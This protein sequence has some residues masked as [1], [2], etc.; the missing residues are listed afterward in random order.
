M[1]CSSSSITSASE[2]TPLHRVV[3]YVGVKMTCHH[4]IYTFKMPFKILIL[5]L[6]CA[7]VHLFLPTYEN[8]NTLV[9]DR[10]FTAI[11]DNNNTCVS[12]QEWVTT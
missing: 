4:P 8:E 12:N 11:P 3:V 10:Q 2:G 6:V 7:P 5:M 1:P 9:V